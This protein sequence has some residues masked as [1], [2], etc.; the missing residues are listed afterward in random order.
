MDKRIKVAILDDFEVQTEDVKP[1]EYSEISVDS[2]GF[3]VAATVEKHSKNKIEFL[4]YDIYNTNN[5]GQKIIRALNRCF[6]YG[7]NIVVMSFV[8]SPW[9]YRYLIEKQ[10]KQLKQNGCKIVA[11][12]YNH[13]NK[14]GYPASSKYVVGV[15]NNNQHE[16]NDRK[17]GIQVVGDVRPEFIK[18]GNKYRI[19]SGTSKA[20]AIIAACMN[21]ECDIKITSEIEESEIKQ[22]NFEQNKLYKDIC[23]KGIMNVRM[24]DDIFKTLKNKE[25][26]EDMVLHILK[27]FGLETK[28]MDMKYEDFKTLKNLMDYI[29]KCYEK[30]GCNS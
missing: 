3:M 22:M 10:L 28:C 1:I 14:C 13:N 20:T 5:Q 8:F 23:Q 26:I 19:F 16:L 6:K 4:Y 18:C 30:M 9:R 11:A 27:L 12:D 25:D 29:G 2:H 17:R 21:D 15:G 24:E 7:V